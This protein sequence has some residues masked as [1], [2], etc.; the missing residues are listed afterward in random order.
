MS[1]ADYHGAAGRSVAFAV[2]MVQNDVLGPANKRKKN[3]LKCSIVC[4]YGRN[5]QNRTE[6]RK[7]TDIKT[8]PYS[9]QALK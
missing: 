7:K 3:G 2:D 9:D 5:E 6:K 8:V 4:S 1:H